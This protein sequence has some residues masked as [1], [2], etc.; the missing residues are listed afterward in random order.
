MN[1]RPRIGMTGEERFVVETKHAIDFADA[2]MPPVLSTPWLIWF[3]EHAARNAL[4]PWLDPGESTVGTEIEVEHFAAT[5][6]GHTVVCTARVVGS[7]GN[8]VW[9]QMEARDEAERVAKGF[10]KRRVISKRRFADR[11]ARKCRR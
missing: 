5:P 1:S 8:E 11:V 2:D 3:L 7:E 6:L 10:H 4:L 9:F